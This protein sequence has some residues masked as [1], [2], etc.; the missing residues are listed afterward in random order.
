MKMTTNRLIALVA[1]L[2]AA[3]ATALSGG[4]GSVVSAGSNGRN[5]R[6]AHHAADA[7]EVEVGGSGSRRLGLQRLAGYQPRTQVTDHAA[8]DQDQASMEE[9]LGLGKLSKA[10]NVYQ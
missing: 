3:T 6:M 7:E 10:M 5:L 2:S 1:L 9:E 4:G 8:L